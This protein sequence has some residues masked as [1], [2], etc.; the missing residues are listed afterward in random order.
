M[1]AGAPGGSGPARRGHPLTASD[2]V[3]TELGGP[4]DLPGAAA[5]DYLAR[6]GVPTDEDREL[7]AAALARI[8]AVLGADLAPGG[9][10]TSPLGPGWTET[11]ACQVLRPIGAGALEAA[12]WLPVDGLRRRCGLPPA[13]VWAVTDG[14]RVLA[15]A[16][17][18][19]GAPADPVEGVLA[20]ARER[21]EVRLLEVLELRALRA[22]GAAFPEA[23]AALTAAA[24]VETGLGRRELVRWTSGRRAVAPAPL[25]GPRRRLV[26]AC[27]GVDGAGKSTLLE[28]LHRDL[29]RCGVPVSRVWLRPGMGLGRLSAV[30]AWVKRRGGMDTRPGI[31][32]VAAD[33]DTVLASRRGL[34]GWLWSLLV[35]LAFVAG[36]RRQHVATRGVVLYDR[37]LVDALV[38]L[39]F[40]YAGVDLRLQRWLVRALVPKAD[41]SVHLDVPVDEAVRRKPGD[42]IGELAVRRQVTAYDRWTGRLG[43]VTRLDATRDPADLRRAAL[44]LVLRGGGQDPD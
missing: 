15:A 28:A 33:P 13:G 25:P 3:P 37:H 41:L 27:S 12:G 39:D 43:G 32:Q 6:N 21:G 34:R 18:G 30:A 2:P 19:T 9:P 11:F 44:E 23:A 29:T 17:V 4:D 5:R 36:V 35:T 22:A 8:R 20:R 42:P 26:V 31:A 14:G 40:A 16:R 1:D 38:T 10:G 7:R 24:D